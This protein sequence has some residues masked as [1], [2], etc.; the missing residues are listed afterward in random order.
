MPADIRRAKILER[1]QRDGG[2]SIGEL[3]RDY[4][5]STITVHRDLERLAG[6]GRVRPAVLPAGSYVTLTYRNHALRANRALL[7][8]AGENKAVLD[9]CDVAAGD[10]FACRYEAYLTDPRTEP[11]KTTW[12]VEL[13][14]RVVAQPA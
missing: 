11:R 3:A 5:V 7:E 13:N 1:I 9:R 14:I 2:A 4:G 10:A 8:W 6:D 12:E